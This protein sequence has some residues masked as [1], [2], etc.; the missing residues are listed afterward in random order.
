MVTSEEYLPGGSGGVWRIQQPDGTVRVHRPSGPWTAAVHA[1]L[2]HLSASGLDGIPRVHGFDEAGREVLDY[3]PGETLDPE[4]QQPSAAALAQA[5]AWLRRFHDAVRGF[6]AGNLEWRQGP[7]G[8]GP[9]EIICHNDPGLYNWVV[10]G[11][12]FAG[13]IDWDRA[14]PG[15]PI[16]DLAFLCW[17]GVP[18]LREIPVADAARRLSVAAAAYGDVSSSALLDAVDDRMELIRERWKAGL[19]RHDPGTEALRDAGIMERH[20]ARVAAF[21]ARRE[22]IRG[23]LSEVRDA[24]SPLRRG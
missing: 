16:D 10:S 6:A 13:M 24:E 1:L 18:L 7:G 3:L 17:S 4:T 20:F 8:P 2:G 9:G 12:S 15:R 19:A 14:G 22:A 21:D 23:A 5:A 11:A